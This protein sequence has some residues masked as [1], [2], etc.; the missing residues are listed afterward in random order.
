MYCSLTYLFL[1]S[2][3][4]AVADPLLLVSKRSSSIFFSVAALIAL[5]ESYSFL[6]IGAFALDLCLLVADSCLTGLL[7]ALEAAL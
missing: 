7:F 1:F 4:F 6:P 3:L 2:A 5:A